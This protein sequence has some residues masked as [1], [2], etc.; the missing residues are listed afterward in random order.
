MITTPTPERSASVSFG[1]EWAQARASRIPHM[2]LGRYR[3]FRED[4][5]E[6]WL[7]ELERRSVDGREA[8]EPRYRSHG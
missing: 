5:L 7:D 4:A 6:Q 1:L 3:R 2:Q 8:R